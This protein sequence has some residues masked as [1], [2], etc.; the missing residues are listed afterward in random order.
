MNI[1]YKHISYHRLW[2]PWPMVKSNCASISESLSIAGITQNWAVGRNA[3]PV[4]SIFYFATFLSVC[5]FDILNNANV[6]QLYFLCLCSFVCL[7]QLCF[8][9]CSVCS[10]RSIWFVQY[11]CHRCW[12]KWFQHSQ[13]VILISAA[14]MKNFRGSF[15]CHNT[16]S[17]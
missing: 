13:H 1:C 16:P 14:Q 10:L 3:F 5:L 7:K 11:T 9:P 15:I 6:S 4:Y 8:I 12:I 2:T 17:G